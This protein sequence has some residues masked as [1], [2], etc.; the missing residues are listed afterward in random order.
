MV[1]AEDTGT[2]IE[3]VMDSAERRLTTLRRNRTYEKG[4]SLGD[5]LSIYMPRLQG[6]RDGTVEP[7]WVPRLEP[8]K[9]VIDYVEDTDFVVVAARPGEGKSS[10]MRYEFFYRAA[11]GKPATIFN[12]E[13]TDNE[14][15]K[16]A[17]ALHARLDSAKIKN[18]R[19]MNDAELQ[20]VKDSAEYLFTVPLRI[21]T[22][23]GPSI[24]EVER[25]ARHEIERYGTTLM[26]LDYL[27][28]VRNGSSDQVENI[29]ETSV[30]V[31]AMALRYKIPFVAASQLS[32]EI[33]KR[34]GNAEPELSDLRG[35]GSIE[36][37]GK[38]IMFPRA[39]PGLNENI[40]RAFPENLEPD[41]S[42]SPLPRVIPIRFHVLKNTNGP[43][44][45]TSPV[46][47]MKHTGDF[48]PLTFRQAPE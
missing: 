34:G 35:S 47:W 48:V 17:L 13:N 19:L 21:V 42:L 23:A 29:T 38:I 27:Q 26:G 9:K 10:W 6:Y 37:D 8:L 32:R 20:R 39:L 41:G 46:A 45:I 40:L 14:Y 15:A 5:I 11:D 4:M 31:R 12:L 36:Q 3:D 24:R 16:G 44:G 25:A 30:A 1:E 28:L 33:V 18:P 43:T 7:A 2:P 22:L